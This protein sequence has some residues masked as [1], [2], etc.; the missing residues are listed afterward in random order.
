MTGNH[1]SLIERLAIRIE[2]VLMTRLVPIHDPG[3]VFKWLFKIPI[4]FYRSGLPLF[5]NF[6]L[7][8]KTT[9]RKSGKKRYTPLEYRLDETTGNFIVM[10]G[11]G[12]RTDWYLNACRNPCVHVQAGRRK[13]YARAEKLE[14]EQVAQW[15]YHVVQVN[16]RSLK[17]WSRWAGE[18]L[19]GTFEGLLRAAKHFP[20]LRLKPMEI[21]R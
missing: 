15:L 4:L 18:E 3:P 7:L 13:F 8:L 21:S 10:A 16:R 12:G 17:I 9:G 1:P 11:W 20:S 14:D 5:G 6:I 2:D 19:D